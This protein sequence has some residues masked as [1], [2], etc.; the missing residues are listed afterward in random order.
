[1]FFAF[2]KHILRIQSIF[3]YFKHL[4]L[5]PKWVL[6]FRVPFFPHFLPLKS[7]KKRVGLGIPSYVVLNNYQIKEVND[8][9]KG[10]IFKQILTQ[11]T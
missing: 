1:M 6:F 10:L 3:T 11:E 8:T 7:L 2:Y 4:F 5:D 9:E